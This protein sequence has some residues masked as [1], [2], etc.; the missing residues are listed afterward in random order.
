VRGSTRWASAR[1]PAR[2]ESRIERRPALGAPWIAQIF[3]PDQQ[4]AALA[5]RRPPFATLF[6]G[7]ERC[8]DGEQHYS[9]QQDAGTGD[10]KN[11]SV[12]RDS[13]FGRHF[14]HGSVRYVN[15]KLS[16]SPVFDVSFVWFLPFILKS[17]ADAKP[18]QDAHRTSTQRP[19]RLPT[20]ANHVRYSMHSP[21]FRSSPQVY[22]R[23]ASLLPSSSISIS[24]PTHYSPVGWPH[25]GHFPLLLPRKS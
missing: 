23:T 18:R 12:S 13:G 4:I 24:Q 21:S 7:P 1:G 19:L 9:H 14:S 17:H 3:Q 6:T 5:T 10:A 25:S 8:E 16:M 2:L 11:L 15:G 22:F 20:D